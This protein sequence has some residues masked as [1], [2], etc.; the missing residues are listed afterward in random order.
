MHL[1]VI[2]EELKNILYAA[3]LGCFFG[4]VYDII[5]IIRLFFGVSEGDLHKRRFLRVIL[6]QITDI[7]YMIFFAVCFCIFLFY[8]N[9]GIFRWYLAVSAAVGIFVYRYTLGIPIM[10]ASAFI[11]K[12]IRLCIYYAVKVP[13][14]YIGRFFIWCFKPIANRM[15]RFMGAKRTERI[16][17][18]IIKDIENCYTGREI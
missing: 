15:T 2:S 11:I 1:S 5:R 12:L 7:I 13:L 8:F 9:S 4:S 14:T 18:Q 10:K 16:L 17:R 3:V 6:L